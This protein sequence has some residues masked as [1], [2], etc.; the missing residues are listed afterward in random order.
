MRSFPLV[1]SFALLAGAAFVVPPPEQGNDYSALPAAPAEV[2]AALARNSVTLG[3]ACEVA[4]RAA[5]GLARSAH[6]LPGSNGLVR[7]DVFSA[8][9]HHLVDVHLADGSVAADNKQPRFPGEPVEGDWKTTPSGLMYWDLKPG[10]G[11]SPLDVHAKVR[12][13]YTGWL[14][15]GTQFDSTRDKNLPLERELSLLIPAWRE[16]LVT[17]KVGGK[18]KLIVPPNLG[19]GARGFGTLIPPNALLVFDMELV[20]VVPPGPAPAAGKPK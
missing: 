6:P 15:D 3:K 12:V 2:N 16:A 13:H 14:N 1:L 20:A 9:E 19:Y 8:T 4:E 7:V 11:E 18:R 17:M 10:T 5:R